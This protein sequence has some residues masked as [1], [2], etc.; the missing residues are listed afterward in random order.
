MCYRA[1]LAIPRAYPTLLVFTFAT[2]HAQRVCLPDANREIAA[3][4]SNAIYCRSLKDYNT[5]TE[6]KIPSGMLPLQPGARIVGVDFI[7][8]TTGYY[9]SGITPSLKSPPIVKTTE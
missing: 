8:K 4:I 2:F 6:V 5:D 3:T 1:A 9:Q 7:F